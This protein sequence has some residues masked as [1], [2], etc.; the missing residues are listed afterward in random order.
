ML[1]L[2]DFAQSMKM[3]EELYYRLKRIL[4]KNHETNLVTML[5]TESLLSELPPALKAE[6]VNFTNKK[7]FTTIPYF[8]GK[9]PNYLAD[10]INC[11]RPITIMAG[12][13]VYRDGDVADESIY[14]YIYI[15][16]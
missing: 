15:L 12:E 16:N 7:L 1:S 13:F 5:D 14:I 2:N 11:L 10:I 3:N 6:V 8:K 9:D 4:K